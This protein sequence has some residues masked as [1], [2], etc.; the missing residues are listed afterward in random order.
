MSEERLN[1]SAV[2]N[3]ESNLT[4]K[5]DNKDIIEE[6]AHK[7]SRQIFEILQLYVYLHAKLYINKIKMY[8]YWIIYI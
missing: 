5:L 8:F 6:F 3:I 4:Q 2:L 1:S 7:Q